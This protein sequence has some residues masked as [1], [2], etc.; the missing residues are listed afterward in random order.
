MDQLWLTVAIPTMDRYSFLSSTLSV[1]LDRPEVKEVLL[2]DENGNDAKEI[3][4]SIYANHP[5]L[6]V[7]V[8]KRRL[9]IYENK[10]QCIL[11]SQGTPM[12]AVLDSDNL[13]NDTWFDILTDSVKLHGFS[14]I[15]ASPCFQSINQT[16]GET[17]QPCMHFSDHWIRSPS[18]WNTT[19]KRDKWNHLLND[20]NWVLPS[21]LAL[22]ALPTNIK[23]SY[24]EAADAIYMLQQFVKAG[25]P[26]WY[27]PKH[28]YVHIV[29]PGSSW[30]QT[31][32]RSTLIFNTTEWDL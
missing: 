8:N 31:T 12:V 19:M 9:G 7:I 14:T 29:H 22:K 4:K 3:E 11:E 2:C 24:L 16:T 20:G 26:V 13:F 23:S 1:Y 17:K 18:D 10:L 30:L 6:R 27:I 28:S 15:Y 5:K 25:I 32:T 21:Q